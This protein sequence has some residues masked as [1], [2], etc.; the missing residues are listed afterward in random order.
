MADKDIFLK[1]LGKRVNQIREEKGLS[2][3]EMALRCDLE[4]SSLVKL[5]NKGTNVTASTLYKIS[6]GLDVSL[7]EVFDF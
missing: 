7:S 2:F 5:A 6:K 1:K 3:Q 4:K